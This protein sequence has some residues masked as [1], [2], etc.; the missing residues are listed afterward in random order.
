M[1]ERTVISDSV[2]LKK[3]F[4]SDKNTS[5]PYIYLPIDSQNDLDKPEKLSKLI[6][7]YKK[8][9]FGGIIPFCNKNFG[10]LIHQ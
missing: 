7:G 1:I 3:A 6:S 10:M 2:A 8:S 5:K 4:Q 9:G